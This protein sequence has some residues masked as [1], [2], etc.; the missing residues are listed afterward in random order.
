MANWALALAVALF[1][2]IARTIEV[3][4]S[5]SCLSTCGGGLTFSTDITCSDRGYNNTDIGRKMQACLECESTSTASLPS[6]GN[7]TAKNDL[8][9]LL[10][11]KA[12]KLLDDWLADYSLNHSQHE[13]HLADVSLHEHF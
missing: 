1:V 5:S 13:I 10:C 2:T 11:K 8:Y 7:D 3:T 9:W 4:S 6:E 12:G